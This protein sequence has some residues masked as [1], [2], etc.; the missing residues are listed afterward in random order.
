MNWVVK[1]EEGEVIV[2]RE[3]GV[4]EEVMTDFHLNNTLH[5]LIHIL[6]LV[7]HMFYLMIAIHDTLL[8]D[9]NYYKLTV[10]V[11]MA[12]GTDSNIFH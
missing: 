5:I 11:E 3:V 7:F 9:T 2:A 10:E 8:L 12:A 1:E 6:N 4:K